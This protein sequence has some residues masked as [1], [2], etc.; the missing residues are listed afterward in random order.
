MAINTIQGV[1]DQIQFQAKQ[2]SAIQPGAVAS[3][4]QNGANKTSQFSDILFNSINNISQM[5]NQARIQSQDYLSGKPGIGLND[6]MV[7]LQK[8]S[9]SLNLGVQ[10]RNKVVSA[11]QDIMNMSV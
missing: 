7:S 1:L 11:Y 4:G 5:Q 2:V 10:V 8:S 6:V 3:G 9:L